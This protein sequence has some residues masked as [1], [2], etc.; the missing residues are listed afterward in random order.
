MTFKNIKTAKEQF[1]ISYLGGIGLSGKVRKS[2]KEGIYTYIL[3]LANSKLS[4]YNVCPNSTPECRLGCLATSGRGGMNLSKYMATR[5]KKT[6]LLFEH[7]KF[8]MEWL[9]AE[10]K[11]AIKKAKRKGFKLVVRLNGTSDI[12]WTKIKV[13]NKNIFEI[14]PEVKFYDYTKCPNRF[15][16]LPKNYHLTFSYTGRNWEKCKKLLKKGFNVAAIFLKKIPKKFRGYRVVDG[17]ITDLR[18]KDKRGIIIGLKWKHIR[19]KEIEKK[20]IKSCF[21]NI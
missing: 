15:A 1:K 13:Y 20:I 2:E 9:V 18:I 3:Y 14:F 16:A 4:G 11:N 6:K 17:D 7:Q 8:F 10:I 19:N 5:I 12:D 21:V